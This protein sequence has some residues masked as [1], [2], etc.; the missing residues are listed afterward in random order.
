MVA[1]DSSPK[2]FKVKN[3]MRGDEGAFQTAAGRLPTEDFS[4]DPRSGSSARE[5]IGFGE[6]GRDN[7]VVSGGLRK[8]SPADRAS[9]WEGL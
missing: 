9:G 2:Q 6:E 4:G 1:V 7:R 5:F 3:G 8:I